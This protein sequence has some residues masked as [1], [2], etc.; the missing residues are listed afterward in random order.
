MKSKPVIRERSLIDLPQEFGFDGLK[1]LK[2]PRP[3]AQWWAKADEQVRA[4]CIDEQAVLLGSGLV[5]KMDSAQGWISASS[6]DVLTQEEYQT[7]LNRLPHTKSESLFCENVETIYFTTIQSSQT[8]VG[9]LSYMYGDLSRAKVYASSNAG[10]T[11][12]AKAIAQIPRFS[13]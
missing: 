12:V 13:F 4:L 8:V 5:A 9:I 2:Q 3:N 11:K 1:L 10:S 7:L 6:I